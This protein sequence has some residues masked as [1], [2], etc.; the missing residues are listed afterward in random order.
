MTL[1]R[2]YLIVFSS[3]GDLIDTHSG[4]RVND[5]GL[6]RRVDGFIESLPITGGDIIYRRSKTTPGVLVIS[7]HF[8]SLYDPTTEDLVRLQDM[9]AEEMMSRE[10]K[11]PLRER[12]MFVLREGF[13][14]TDAWLEC[15]Q[16]VTGMGP[17][18]MTEVHRDAFVLQLKNGARTTVGFE[19]AP[20][21]LRPLMTRK[22]AAEIR[23]LGALGNIDQTLR[24]EIA[25]VLGLD[26][27]APSSEPDL[28]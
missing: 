28:D 10:S 4:E 7:Y 27:N 13:F 23:E 11:L 14:D 26:A 24:D 16:F 22:E 2:P 19:E 9:V 5:E 8:R 20:A 21:R 15:E 6:L 3:H 12:E 25:W 1:P 17:A 18:R